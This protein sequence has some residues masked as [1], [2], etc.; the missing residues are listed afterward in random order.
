MFSGIVTELGR[1]A[2]VEMG[3]GHGRLAV[4][5][6]DV[7]ADAVVGDSV[8]VNGVCLTI[9]E[10]RPDG[11]FVAD[12]MGET[13][14]RTGLGALEPGDPVDLEPALPADGRLG[15]H[16][17]QGHVDGVAE[18]TDVTE[19]EEWTTMTFTLPPDL[20]PY[21]VEKGSITLAGVSLTVADVTEDAFAVG[22]IPHTLKVTTLGGLAV[23]DAVNAEADVVAKYVER[24]L[25]GRPD[26]PYVPQEDR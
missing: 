5:C 18:V 2:A 17:V 10:L 24:L 9:T 11:G 12:V 7:V 15:G 19:H 14:S 21:V 23:G 25:A 22:L 1:V 4:T 26:S 6:H 8:S 16:L 3:E 13:L 20:E